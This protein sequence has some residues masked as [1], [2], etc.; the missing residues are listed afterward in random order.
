MTTANELVTSAMRLVGAYGVDEAPSAEDASAVLSAL[1]QMLAGWATEGIDLEHSTLELGDT[2]PYP[3]DHLRGI[4]Y[5][6]ALEIGP[7]F[8][9]QIRRDVA[10]TAHATKRAL[11][12]IYAQPPKLRADR[13]L[14]PYYNP[15]ERL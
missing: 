5:N 14:H 8:G 10:A 4:R 12:A 2:L 9:A 1:N 13:A 6:L 11:R 15:N 7:E 3:D